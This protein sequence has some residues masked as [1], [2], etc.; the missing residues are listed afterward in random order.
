MKSLNVYLSGTE[1]ESL[2]DALNSY[3]H[4]LS[5]MS[6]NTGSEEIEKILTQLEEDLYPIFH[7]LYKGYNGEKYYSP[8]KTHKQE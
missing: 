4:M 7:K 2:I 3:I 5:T 1:R 6:E 8:H